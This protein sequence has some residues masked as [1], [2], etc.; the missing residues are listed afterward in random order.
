MNRN[1][2]IVF[3]FCL[4]GCRKPYN[5]PAI[6]AANS[7]LV[8]QGVINPG[9]DSTIIL[10]SKTVPLS[11][12]VAVN[13]LSGA[14]VKVLSDQ[15]NAY[16]L[17]E[18]STG[19]YTSPGLNVDYSRQ[20]RLDIKTPDGQHYQSDL[21]PVTIS[22]PIDSLGFNITTIP[23]TGIQIYANA[24]DATGQV[25]YF[26]WEY[27]ENWE[28]HPKFVS[29]YVGNGIT[30]VKRSPLPDISNC[31]SSDVSSDIVLG[32]TA[33]LSQDILYQSPITFIASTSE[34][35]ESRYRILV[36]QYALTGPEYAFWQ[37][38]RTNT[39]QLGSIFD[40]EPSEVPGNVHCINDPAEPVAGYVGVCAVS[41]K[42]MFVN[43]SQLPAWV[44]DYPY[45]CTLI[46]ADLYSPAY[47][48]LVDFPDIYFPV[49]SGVDVASKPP[50]KPAFFYTNRVCAD[51][52]IRG[53]TVPPPYWQ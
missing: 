8:V 46:A 43:A 26:R 53:S 5:P 32:S 44:P 19:T 18:T 52:S 50:D 22:P 23:V 28:F 16:P 42:I 34:K 27:N 20:Y 36:R 9:P 39:E 35:I 24:H 1:C 11:S 30:I 10:L 6:A 38:L 41:T 45:S 17:A 37:N 21:E 33:K 12:N 49:D 31:Y 4:C 25:K 47:N 15:N 29:P 7:Y 14:I 2:W 51:C 13:P 3:A 48:L 40:A